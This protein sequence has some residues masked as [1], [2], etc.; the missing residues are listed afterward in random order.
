M[1]DWLTD[2]WSQEVVRRA[3]AEVVLLGVVGGAL[4]GN[5][6]THHSTVGTIV[7]AGVGGAAGHEIARNNC[8]GRA[9]R[10]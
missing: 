9:R 8:S 7:G 6:I 1:I 4:I 2:P 10:R 3:F 5:A